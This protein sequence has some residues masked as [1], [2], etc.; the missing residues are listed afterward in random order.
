MALTIALV[1]AGKNRL[2]YLLTTAS[3]GTDTGSITTTGAATP[4]IQTDIG[5]NGGQL[6][7]I[8][9]AITAGY[10]PFASGAQT[11][12]KARALWLSDRANGGVASYNAVDVGPPSAMCELTKR[13]GPHTWFVDANVSGGNPTIDITAIGDGV[14]AA[15][16]CY[17]DVFIPGA[18]GA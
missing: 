17:L 13:T 7:S 3:N 1:F 5:T 10:G 15:G 6:K 11:Q 14:T 18:I 8:A 9:K 2:R 16:T 12:A 4:D